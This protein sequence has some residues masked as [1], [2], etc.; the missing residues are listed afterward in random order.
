L[1]NHFITNIHSILKLSTLNIFCP[2]AG[3]ALPFPIDEKEAK[4]YVQIKLSPH[5]LTDSPY[6]QTPP[7]RPSIS[8]LSRRPAY[9]PVGRQFERPARR[10]EEAFFKIEMVFLRI[11]K[12]ILPCY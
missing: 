9:L 5:I 11:Y 12:L 4:I 8:S 10:I 2:Y 1:R 7:K 6:P 3:Q